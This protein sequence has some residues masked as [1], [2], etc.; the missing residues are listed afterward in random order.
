MTLCVVYTTQKCVPLSFKKDALDKL[1]RY[2]TTRMTKNLKNTCEFFEKNG[3][4]PGER[5][6]GWEIEFKRQTTG[7]NVDQL[8]NCTQFSQT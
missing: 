5:R 6:G 1:N 3:N 8:W 2:K 7:Q 4:L